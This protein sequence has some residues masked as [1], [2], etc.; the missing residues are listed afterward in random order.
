MDHIVLHGPRQSG[1]TTLIMA[2]IHEQVLLGNRAHL[3]LVF[4][5]VF[6]AE[7]WLA[8]WHNLYPS[9]TAPDYMTTDNPLKISG[10]V[11]TRA[12]IEN[13]DVY[14]EGIFD[15]KLQYVLDQVTEVVTYTSS[16]TV[17]SSR[18]HHLTRTGFWLD[19]YEIE[20][21]NMRQSASQSNEQ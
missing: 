14:R 15:P 2:E 13:I 16:P 6:Q 19:P 12:Y 7:T 17:L 3:L 21:N 20:W 18:S 9:V 5:E 8:E 10:R 11:F 4:N 1:K